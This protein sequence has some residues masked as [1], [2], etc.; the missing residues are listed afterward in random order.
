MRK[1]LVL[2][3]VLFMS[4][5]SF[6]QVGDEFAAFFNEAYETYPNI[7]EGVL[8]AVAYTQTRMK[9]IRPGTESC[10]ELPT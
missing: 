5:A 4:L 6:A 9:H 2:C 7:P 3:S 1:L 10:L 8:E